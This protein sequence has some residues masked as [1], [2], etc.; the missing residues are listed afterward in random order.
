MIAIIGGGTL[1]QRDNEYGHE[2]RGGRHRRRRDH[3]LLQLVVRDQ[4]TPIAT[5]N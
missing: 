1:N 5:L 3:H 2:Q 4:R